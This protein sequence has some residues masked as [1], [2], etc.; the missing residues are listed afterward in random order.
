V[1]RLG[2]EDLIRDAF[3]GV[4]LGA[5]VSLRQAAAIDVYFEG[6]TQAQFDRLPESEVTHDWTE[7]PDDELRR[8]NVAHL[9]PE[10]LRYYLPALMLWLLEHYNNADERLLDSDA[11]MSVIG[12]IYALAPGKDFREHQYGIYDAFFTEQQRCAI[13]AYVATLPGLVE[14]GWE[15]TALLE[16]S[17]RD[18]WGQF[19]THGG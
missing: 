10:G 12:T 11:E 18:Y 15:D 16:R 3:A 19:L 6:W 1:E 17:L 5:G 13:A 9:D 2:L 14:L 7:I 4:S 8:D